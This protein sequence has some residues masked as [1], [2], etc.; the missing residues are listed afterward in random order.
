MNEESEGVQLKTTPKLIL[1][2]N[3]EEIDELYDYMSLIYKFQLLHPNIQ[4]IL[5]FDNSI[6]FHLNIGMNI[7]Y[8]PDNFFTGKG[9][10]FYPIKKSVISTKGFEWDVCNL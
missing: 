6:V 8:L 9:V 10:G 5:L 4:F 3:Y 7:V 1:Y 2:L